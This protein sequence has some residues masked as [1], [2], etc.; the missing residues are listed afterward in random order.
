MSEKR[1]TVTQVT[2]TDLENLTISIATSSKRKPNS[3]SLL[4]TISMKRMAQLAV[5]TTANGA[6]ERYLLASKS[7]RRTVYIL[8]L[9]SL[10]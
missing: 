9:T 4:R 8:R 10:R 5:P 6:S 2:R 3:S 7:D 1:V